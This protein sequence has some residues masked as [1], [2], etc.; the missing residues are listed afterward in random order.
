MSSRCGGGGVK[1]LHMQV[2]VVPGLE[3]KAG[4]SCTVVFRSLHSTIWL[5]LGMKPQTASRTKLDTLLVLVT[6]L[7]LSFAVIIFGLDWMKDT[8][9]RQEK[10]SSKHRDSIEYRAREWLALE[11]SEASMWIDNSV[12]YQISEPNS[13]GEWERLVPVSGTTISCPTDSES[14]D[15]GNLGTGGGGG[16]TYTVSLFHQLRCLEIIRNDYAAQETSQMS[17]HCL[18]YLRQILLCFAD[19][20]L[21]V[22]RSDRPPNVVSFGSDY[23]CRDWSKI[24]ASASHNQTAMCPAPRGTSA[25]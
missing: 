7:T 13:A 2:I 22:I 24:Y 9:S 23:N 5:P 19:T 3:G 17:Q 6:T 18:N 10:I 8:I 16:G 4:N 12:R 21:E 15:R 14:S 1:S 25:P 20:R 11:E